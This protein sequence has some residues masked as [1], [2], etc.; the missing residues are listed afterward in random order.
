MFPSRHI[1]LPLCLRYPLT[2]VSVPPVLSFRDVCV[3][4]PLRGERQSRHGGN[5]PN[6]KCHSTAAAPTVQ[7]SAGRGGAA[8]TGGRVGLWV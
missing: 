8:R 3:E 5:G 2:P 7:P 1:L 6:R 4:R